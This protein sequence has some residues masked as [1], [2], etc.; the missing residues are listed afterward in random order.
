MT[1][2]RYRR[3]LEGQ[4]MD[5]RKTMHLSDFTQELRENA[6]QDWCKQ[7]EYDPE[8]VGSAIAYEDYFNIHDI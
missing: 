2:K 1:D 5:E 4:M 8:A 6:Y 3:Y 7:N